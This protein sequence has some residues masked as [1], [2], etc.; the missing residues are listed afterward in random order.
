MLQPKKVK[1]KTNEFFKRKKK[2]DFEISN[3]T[4][5][6]HVSLIEQPQ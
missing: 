3:Y 6:A 4:P 5:T 2:G 1:H